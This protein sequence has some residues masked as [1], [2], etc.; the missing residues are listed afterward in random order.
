LRLS[1]L[2]PIFLDGV[3]APTAVGELIF[4]PLPSLS[5]AQ[6][7]DLLQAIRIRALGWLIRQGVIRSFRRPG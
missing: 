3:F 6:L 4:H 5:S 7:A 1:P 2:H